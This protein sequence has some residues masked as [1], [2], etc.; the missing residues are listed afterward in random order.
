MLDDEGYNGEEETKKKMKQWKAKKK[1][2][3]RKKREGRHIRYNEKINHDGDVS[4]DFQ[5][6]ED[7]ADRHNN[8]DIRGEDE[9]IMTISYSRIRNTRNNSDPQK[10]II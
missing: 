5:K 4:D 10:Q 1:K 3:N 9:D 6:T 2:K 8:D 7:E